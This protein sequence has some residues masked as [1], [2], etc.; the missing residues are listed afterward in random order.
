M[1]DEDCITDV[2]PQHIISDI[3]FGAPDFRAAISKINHNSAV[4]S[5]SFL[6]RVLKVCRHQLAFLYAN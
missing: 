4:G 5:V 6:A 3:M 1:L 2:I